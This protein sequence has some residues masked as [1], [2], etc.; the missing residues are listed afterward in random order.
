MTKDTKK[1]KT[2]KSAPLPELNIGIL[3]H[4]DHGKTTLTQ[5]LTGK[6]TDEHSEELKR[7]ISIRLGYADMNI[8]K[9][10]KCKDASGYT[11]FPKCFTCGSDTKHLRTL[12]IVDVPGHETLM[13]TVLTGAS[14]LDGAILVIAANEKCPQPQTKEHL[15]VL[16]ISGIK[17]I[18]VVQNKID[19][20]DAAGAKKNYDSIKAFLKG[21][22][23]E[24]A[25]IIPI[26]A[27]H[28]ANI[29]VLLK[30]MQDILITPKHDSKKNSKMLVARSFDVN[31]PGTK[32]SKLLGGVIGGSIVDG[33][34][35]PGDEVELRPGVKQ[36][37][38]WNPIKT[39]I[40]SINKGKSSVK[41]GTPGGLIAISTTLD[42]YIA[43]SDSLVGN[44]VG[45]PGKMPPVW[46]TLKLEINIIEGLHETKENILKND[47]ILMGVGTARTIGVCTQPGKTSDFVLKL[48]VCA[49]I[50]DKVAL[51]KQVSGRFRLIG[52]GIVK[53]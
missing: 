46:K 20:V 28:K 10:P 48:P 40:I 53:K 23:A 8:N 52:Y 27:Q 37:N 31:R 30:A 15:A 34:F 35:K 12:S 14:L 17:N 33:V 9:C 7:G 50:G 13:A 38:D 1:E 11:T 2:I 21:S 29:E 47:P 39:K 36:N 51:S 5:M 49:D 44:V 19:L 18:I 32:I 25:P 6:F 45:I 3:G 4:V 42:P 22:V 41:E 43:K 24:N 16:N 26:S